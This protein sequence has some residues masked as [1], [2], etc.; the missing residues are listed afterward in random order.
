MEPRSALEHR[1]LNPLTPY[2][3][4]AWTRELNRFGLIGRFA[5]I[6]E[7]FRNGFK[8]DFPPITTVQTPPM[9]PIT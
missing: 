9:V 2:K 5:K 8:I 4:E 3:K 7:G 6:P 1:K